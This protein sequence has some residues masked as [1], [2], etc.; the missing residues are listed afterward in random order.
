M[1]NKWK[2]LDKSTKFGIKIGL[3]T[4][5]VPLWVYI[6]YVFP[7]IGVLYLAVIFGGMAAKMHKDASRWD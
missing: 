3:F 2:T 6:F 7:L 5:T 1:I 4:L